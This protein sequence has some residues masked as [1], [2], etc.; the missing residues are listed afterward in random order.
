MN[1]QASK[2]GLVLSG[3][4]AKGAYQVG[5]IRALAQLDVPVSLVAGASIGALNGAMVCASDDLSQAAHRLEK[6]WT[7]LGA[8]S[9]LELNTGYI[10]FLAVVGAMA[11]ARLTPV[12]LAMAFG[13]SVAG[14]MFR[15][16]QG[17]SETFEEG[18][19]KL[20]PIRKILEDNLSLDAISKGPEL[21]V[22]VYPAGGLGVDL[23]DYISSAVGLVENR[24]S[25]FLHI[26]SLPGEQQLKA[27]LASAA[28]P[29][30]FEA[31][32]VQGKRYRDGGMGGNQRVQG[33]TPADP[34]IEAGCRH[35]IVTH[36]SDGSLWSRSRYPNTTIIEIRP[37]RPM[38]RKAMPGA[39]M[40]SFDPEVIQSR[41]KEGFED[42]IACIE[43]IRQAF[44]VRKLRQD[45]TGLRD[46][47]IDGAIEGVRR[48]EEDEFSAR[49][50]RDT[51][52][53][54]SGPGSDPV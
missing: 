44:Q 12:G 20:G 9:P 54:R 38:E 35:L 49:F 24:A 50:G 10:S 22:S 18:L 45:S 29:L 11:G 19:S 8:S 30:I 42:T 1:L 15:G 34:L 14:K 43:P 27:I 32:E 41:M 28:L 39:D 51:G 48:L 25:E 53:R 36:L 33:N 23:L 46:R 47:A 7:Q 3:G 17:K 16:E 6:L 13:T 2:V 21:H 31:Q 4:G 52:G 37:S 26:Q 5:V 40:I